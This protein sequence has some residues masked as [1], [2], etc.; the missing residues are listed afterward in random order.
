M[1]NNMVKILSIF[2]IGGMLFAWGLHIGKTCNKPTYVYGKKDTVTNIVARPVTIRDT[3]K[4][5]SVMVKYKDTTYFIERP[6]E[7]PCK[8]TAFIAQADSV[9]TLTKDTINMA[10]N[11]RDGLG[12]FSLVFK[13]RPDSIQTI[14]VPVEKQVSDYTWLPV[15]F[16]VG[17][18]VGIWGARP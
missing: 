12:H 15:T 17:A 1:S 2:L 13:P 9:I 10:F 3:I 8:D 11:Y 14:T 18:L 5:K 16:V 6:I 7:I 4:T